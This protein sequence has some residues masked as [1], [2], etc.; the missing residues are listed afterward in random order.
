M[1]ESTS[2]KAHVSSRKARSVS[3]NLSNEYDEP[4]LD[5]KPEFKRSVSISA[6]KDLFTGQVI[7]VLTSGGDAQGQL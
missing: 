4:D 7:G 5:L 6:T 3:F 1:S 2:A